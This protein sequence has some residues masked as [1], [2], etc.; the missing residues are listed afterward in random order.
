MLKMKNQ[1]VSIL[2]TTFNHEK[3]IEDC[4]LSCL[5]QTYS[6]FEVLVSDDNSQDQT[7]LILQKFLPTKNIKIYNQKKNIG[8]YKNVNFLLEKA[9]GELICL[10]S[11]DDILYKT[12]L[13]EKVQ[14]FN[15]FENVCM[16]FNAADKIDS[17]GI[18][19]QHNYFS[20]LLDH[21][22]NLSNFLSKGFYIWVNGVML[23]KETIGN[24]RYVKP[25][26]NVEFKLFH[27]ILAAQENLEFY[28]IAHPLCAWR[29]HKYSYSLN[30]KFEAGLDSLLLELFLYIKYINFRTDTILRINNS[31]QIL[32]EL[33]VQG[34]IFFKFIRKFLR[35]AYSIRSRFLVYFIYYMHPVIRNFSNLKGKK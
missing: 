10:M 5:D 25:Y 35:N 34:S 30:Y 28:F 22:G 4:I 15:D 20:N 14:I 1:L 7:Q 11:G 12:A 17:C 21:R 19:I 9:K 24:I 2:V 13:E 33:N 3:Y 27:D 18:N 6:N 26:Q 32:E 29:R 16:V 31:S 23:R 8:M